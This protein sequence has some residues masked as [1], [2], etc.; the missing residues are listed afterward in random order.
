MPLDDLRILREATASHQA[1]PDSIQALRR[2]NEAIRFAAARHSTSE[3]A[4]AAKIPS[5]EIDEVL[6]PLLPA[7]ADASLPSAATDGVPSHFRSSPA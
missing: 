5:A 6:R 3:I 1:S 2:R 7:A 4:E